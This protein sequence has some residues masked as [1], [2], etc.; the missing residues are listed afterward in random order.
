M[1]KT[2]LLA[3]LCAALLTVSAHAASGVAI[4]KKGDT[5]LNIMVNGKLFT[6]YN[7]SNDAK[8]PYLWPVNAE[9]D[10]SITRNWPMGTDEKPAKDHPHHKGIWSAYGDFRLAPVDPTAEKGVDCWDEGQG[11]G[12]QHSD[13]VTN[14]AADGYAW[15]KAKNTWQ[16]NAHKPV[17]AESR[18]YRFYAAPDN[19]RYFDLAITF[20]AA[21]GT[22]LFKDT[23]EGGLLAFRIRPDLT[24]TSKNGTITNS[25][26]G[27]GSEQ[28]W[29]KPADWTDYY[30]EIT[31]K[32]VRGIAVFDH[33][34][35]MRH[36]TTWH[37][38][39]YGLNGANCFGLSYFTDG[40]ENGDF[41][42]E[43]GKSVTFN[44]RV[45]IHSGSSEEAGIAK[46]YEDYAKTE[47]I[48]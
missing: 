43:E 18:E 25:A 1:K 39:D 14:G 27:K 38:R 28:C 15:I 20:T 44:Y 5:Q 2:F 47:P 22:V 41:T 12:F 48:K 10:V 34:G 46:M 31:G 33:P 17:I 42:L 19:A 23:K 13:E 21:Y 24:E 35:N 29:G 40:K 4:E 37:I 8:K 11:S 26:G 3:F 30:G 45:V 6:T 16:D 7:Y 9:G 36:P 32:G